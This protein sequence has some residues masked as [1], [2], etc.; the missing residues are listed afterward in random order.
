MSSK[1]EDAYRLF[2]IPHK[3]RTSTIESSVRRLLYDA[4]NKF[5]HWYVL[6]SLER[7]QY[8]R[9]LNN[10]YQNQFKDA[11]H[12]HPIPPCVSVVT[13]EKMGLFIGLHY[14]E[15]AVL[16]VDEAHLLVPYLRNYPSMFTHFHRFARVLHFTYHLRVCDFGYLLDTDKTIKRTLTSF[17]N[18]DDDAIQRLYGKNTRPLSFSRMAEAGNR[19]LA[20]QAVTSAILFN[21][22]FFFQIWIKYT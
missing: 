6:T 12:D 8:W 21:M 4:S 17:P 20:Q 10:T 16:I 22:Y 2:L 13:F 19:I 1:N 11:K 9:T 5:D 15:T 7:E 14:A 3:Q 18:G